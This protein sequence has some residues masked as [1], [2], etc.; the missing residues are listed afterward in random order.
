M[1]R[2]EPAD[3]SIILHERTP[4]VIASRHSGCCVISYPLLK[5][6]YPNQEWSES[7]LRVAPAEDGRTIVS[8]DHE[9]SNGVYPIQYALRIPGRYDMRITD[10]AGQV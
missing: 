1:S 2:C 10:V 6:T 7:P 4:A 9:A 5:K 8:V 3:G